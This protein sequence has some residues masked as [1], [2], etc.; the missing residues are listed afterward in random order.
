MCSSATDC[1]G[2]AWAY[3][4][5]MGLQGVLQAVIVA[6]VAITVVFMVVRNR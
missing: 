1:L 3:I 6:A 2:M 5:T 4:G